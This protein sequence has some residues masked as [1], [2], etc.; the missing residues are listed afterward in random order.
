VRRDERAE[1]P[2]NLVVVQ[3]RHAP[4][5]TLLAS[6]VAVAACGPVVP[7]KAA[8][9]ERIGMVSY[10]ESFS[11]SK[12]T[13]EVSLSG[14]ALRRAVEMMDR[15]GVMTMPAGTHEVKGVLDKSTLTLVIRTVDNRERKVIMKNCAESHICAFFAEAVKGGVVDKTPALCRD[16]VACAK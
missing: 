16:A 3:P 14:D 12:E 5:A 2:Y 6:V 1:G 9:G 15:A 7:V 8:S 4:L 10:E 11:L 13:Q